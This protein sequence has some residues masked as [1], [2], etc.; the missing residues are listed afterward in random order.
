MTR[1]LLDTQKEPRQQHGGSVRAGD[2][3]EP[4]LIGPRRAGCFG[5]M[6]VKLL[7]RFTRADRNAL[8]FD[9]LFV[10]NQEGED[11]ARFV[12]QRIAQ[13]ETGRNGLVRPKRA[14]AFNLVMLGQLSPQYILSDDLSARSSY[15]VVRRAGRL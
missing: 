11:A 9:D 13:D 8:L 3:D 2:F 4:D 14:L 7:P 10:A 5:E 1:S 6:K 15:A 12:T